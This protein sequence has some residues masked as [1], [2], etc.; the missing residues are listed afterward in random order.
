MSEYKRYRERALHIY[1]YIYVYIYHCSDDREGYQ[2]SHIL[3]GSCVVSKISIYTHR[4][5]VSQGHYDEAEKLY[6]RTLAIWEK[7]SGP[8]HGNVETV[9]SDLAGCLKH[10]VKHWRTRRISR[11]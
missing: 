9:L 4:W 11:A 2:T 6:R 10:Q 3:R 8:E 7:A 5:P 1:I